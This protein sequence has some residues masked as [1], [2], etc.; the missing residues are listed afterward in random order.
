MYAFRRHL[1]TELRSYPV[2]ASLGLLYRLAAQYAGLCGPAREVGK[3]MGLASYGEIRQKE[4]FDSLDSMLH[5]LEKHASQWSGERVIQEIETGTMSF[6]TENFFPYEA[7]LSRDTFV[8]RHFA[9]FIQAYLERKLLGYVR[10]CLDLAGSKRLALAGG[11]ALNCTA[12]R[13][14]ADIC[15]GEVFIQPAS[16]DAGVALGAAILARHTATTVQF[17]HAYWGIAYSEHEWLER[18]QRFPHLRYHRYDCPE[19]LYSQIVERLTT[20]IIG[21]L[22]LGRAE[23]RPRALGNRSIIADPRRRSIL[24][25]VNG[26]KGREMWRPLAPMILEEHFDRFFE[27]T[28]NSFMIV[29]ATVRDSVRSR[30]PVNVHTDYSARPQTV[31]QRQ[32]FFLHNLISAFY[33]ATG[34]PVLMNTSLNGPGRPIVHDP[35]DAMEFLAGSDLDFIATES[36]LI[37]K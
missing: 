3:F 22:F 35:I 6:F 27:G 19:K 14:I 29:A 1:L 4:L 23:I 36:L 15:K 8:Y 18:L 9:A 25:R 5:D 16:H 31:S 7:E 37:E 30:I 21:S 12:N 17:P 32:N 13:R 26:I 20:G 24:E 10:E 34:I 2:T 11:V 33:H 28:P